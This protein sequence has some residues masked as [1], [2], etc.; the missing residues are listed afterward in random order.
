MHKLQDPDETS[1]VVPLFRLAFRPFFL[2]G[3]LYSMLALA[4]WAAFWLGEL[5]WIPHGGWIWWHAHEMIFG[6]TCAI[7][8]GFLLT[9][10]QNWTGQPGINSWPLA[11]IFAVWLIPRIFLLY[12]IAAIENLVIALDLAF[13]PLTA[14]LLASQVWRVRQFHNLVFVPL[15]L[16]MASINAQMH[17][18][19]FEGEGSLARSASHSAVFVVVLLVVV[20]GGR[21]IPFFTENG[22]ATARVMPH[23]VIET[24]SLGLVGVLVLLQLFGL[25]NYLPPLLVAGL[26]LL[27]G[28]LHLLRL[29]RWRPWITLKQPLLWS[30]HL[31]YLFVVLGLFF[32]AVRFAGESLEIFKSFTSQGA[33]LLHSFTLGSMGLLI[34]SMMSR[35]SLGHTGRPLSVGPLMSFSFLCV[36]SAAICRVWLPLFFP[37][38]SHTWSYLLSILLWV[39]GYGLFVAIYQPILSAPRIDGRSG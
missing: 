15:L 4:L 36:G 20:M 18:A 8:I 26:F 23:P 32:F 10:V 12:P 13:L 17:W 38:I 1:R 7:I 25:F 5:R 27:A 21:V 37:A 2:G 34:L 39:L 14:W 35:V 19:I 29:L 31:A 33:T 6:F 30:L 24:L 16:L 9:A 22:T 28:C 3:A 11:G